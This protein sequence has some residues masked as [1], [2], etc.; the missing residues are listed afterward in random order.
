MTAAECTAA[1]GEVV[2]DIGDGATSRPDYTCPNSGK[3]PLG[4]I[5]A[6]PGGAQSIEG[7][8]CCK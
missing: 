2:G 8:V 6:D 1:G 7:S 4:H 3:P 5:Q